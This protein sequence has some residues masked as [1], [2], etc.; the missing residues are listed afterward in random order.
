M[1]C[2]LFGQPLDKYQLFIVDAQ[3][4]KNR[5]L[6]LLYN[7]GEDKVDKTSGEVPDPI[8]QMTLDCRY[9]FSRL[10]Q[11]ARCLRSSSS[12]SFSIGHTLTI[13]ILFIFYK[14]GGL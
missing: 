14:F 10:I 2:S 9:N 7:G 1:A 8:W 6:R 12:A 5:T 13:P 3:I 4:N 11:Y